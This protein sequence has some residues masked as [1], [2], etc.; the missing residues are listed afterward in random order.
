M[1]SSRR[2]RGVELGSPLGHFAVSTASSILLVLF[3][4]SSYLFIELPGM[5]LG[6]KLFS[7]ELRFR[8]FL[9]VV[10]RRRLISEPTGD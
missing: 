7:R 3:A 5:E 8:E 9:P 2:L 1:Y 4:A 10:V 6:R